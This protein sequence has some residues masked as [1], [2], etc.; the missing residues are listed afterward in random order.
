M[1]IGCV[2]EGWI[3][4]LD[5]FFASSKGK[6]LEKFLEEEHA[7]GEPIYPP[8]PLRALKLVGP[9]EVK[10]VIVGQDPYHGPGQANGLAFSVNPD[11]PIPGSLRNIFKEIGHEY[12]GAEFRN[13]DLTNWARQGVLLINSVLT[14]TQGQPGR[15]A[16]KGWE[17]LTDSLLKV[18]AR[19]GRPVVYMLWGNY[20]K[21]KAPLIKEHGGR[22]L[23]LESNHPSPLSALRPP[24]PFIGNGHFKSANDWLEANGESPIQWCERNF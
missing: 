2:K 14:V 15:H 6:R 12:G 22:V 7:K 18:T 24:K 19:A 21:R 9:D 10:V 11:I 5:Q 23:I 17:E 13:G 1:D 8:D 4:I 3:E 20:A 16:G